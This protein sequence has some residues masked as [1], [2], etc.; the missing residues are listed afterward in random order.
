[1]PALQTWE[2]GLEGKSGSCLCGVSICYD[3]KGHMVRQALALRGSNLNLVNCILVTL[4]RSGRGRSDSC[5]LIVGSSCEED[6]NDTRKVLEQ[7]RVSIDYSWPFV[8][9]G[10]SLVDSTNYGSEI[11][12]NCLWGLER[13]LSH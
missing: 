3:K 4:V 12:F 11:F 2:V 6:R 5:H 13:W 8:E 1:M 10:S 9:T 7:N